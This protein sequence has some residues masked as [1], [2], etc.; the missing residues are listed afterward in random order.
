MIL[1]LL[2]EHLGLLMLVTLVVLIMT[3]FPVAFTLMGTAV[4]FTVDIATLD[5]L[6]AQLLATTGSGS[7]NARAELLAE[8]G[9]RNGGLREA[10][11]RE[12]LRRPARMSE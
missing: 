3:G 4:G 10:G 12:L 2:R 1:E 9:A 6:F 11:A 8:L 5:D 7:R